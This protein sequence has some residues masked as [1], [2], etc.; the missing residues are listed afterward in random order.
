MKLSAPTM[1]VFVISLVLGIL[2][3]VGSFGLASVPYAGWLLA[4]GWGLLTLAN[5]IKGL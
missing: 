2:G 4:G 3:V 5:V 1:P